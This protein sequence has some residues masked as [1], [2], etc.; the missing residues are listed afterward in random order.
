[1]AG[2]IQFLWLFFG[3]KV[4]EI[5]EPFVKTVNGR[6]KFVPIAEMIFTELRGRVALRF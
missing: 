3:V 4:I 5:S 2:V 1:L 6:Q